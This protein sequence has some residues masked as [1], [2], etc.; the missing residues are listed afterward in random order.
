MPKS[1]TSRRWLRRQ[2]TD[3]F[4]ARARRAGYRSRASYKLLELDQREHLFKPG[5]C[6][7]DLGAAPGGWSQVAAARIQHRDQANHRGKVLACDILPM[8]PLAGVDF[9]QG[10]FTEDAVWQQIAQTLAD[11]PVDL[12]L[13]D[14]APNLSG[15]RALDQPRAMHLAE[16]AFDAATQMLRPGGTLVVKL[17]MGEGFDAYCRT[18]RQRFARVSV[19]KP[20]ASRP[21]SAELYLVAHGLR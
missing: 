20:A 17:F 4:V 19:R 10:D 1:A 5:Q 14:M 13:S 9:I 7:L 8:P 2:H 6:V 15:Q 21:R 11:T 18:A 3:D 16:L 12:L